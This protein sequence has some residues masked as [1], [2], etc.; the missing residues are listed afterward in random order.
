MRAWLGLVAALVL[1]VI[2]A[3][4]ATTPPAPRDP[5]LT[6]GLFDL[7]RA[8]ANLR[9]IARAPHPTGSAENALVR[10][11]LAGEMARIGM[12]VSTR[13]GVLDAKSTQR[14]NKWSGRSD[15][16]AATVNLVGVLPGHDRAAPAVLLM[17]H[18]DSVWG[19]PGASD[20]GAGM[21][22]ALEVARQV[23]AKGP[24]RRDLIVLLTDGEELG[25]QGAAQFFAGD[26]L[27]GHIGAVIN[28]EARGGGGRTTLFQT[29]AG[30]GE[31]VTA[32]ARAVHRPGGSSL[33]AYIYSVLPND[34][35]LTPALKGDWAAWNFAFIGRPGLYHSPKATPEALDRG[36]LQD[37]GWQVSELT[38]ALL[39]APELPGKAHDVVF[40]DLFGLVLLSWPAWLGWVMLAVAAGGLVLAASREGNLRALGSGAG[41]MAALIVLAAATLFALNLASGAGQGANYYDRLAAIPL[42]EVM[43]LLAALGC[44]MVVLG[45]G[46]AGAARQAGAALPLLVIAAAMQGI[47][48]TA[49]YVAVVP[50]MVGA[51]AL[52][53]GEVL[54]KPAATLACAA[55][56]GPIV[57]YQLALGHQLM[58]GVG[59]T[60]PSAAAL[61]LA[62]GAL[63][64]LPLWPGTSTRTANLTGLA[65]LGAALAV[66]LWVRLDPMADTVAIYSLASR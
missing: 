56:A 2:L 17:A 54:A 41:R 35:D 6:Q 27:L 57:G 39:A 11:F 18:H 15:P 59:P 26:P 40:F 43:V 1:G 65:L 13:E 58:Q 21:A 48:P 22:T 30:N 38:Q 14:L 49:A 66:A 5:R 31:A 8:E 64:I 24:P 33:A 52:V 16:P 45:K 32:Y 25:L 20:D 42:L 34:T 37:M 51:V 10:G 60:L 28:M 53:L 29:S 23:A 55:L 44:F 12:D 61:P 50:V 19:S 7:P 4:L 46:F 62:L 36:A 9:R 63:V 3:I 47:A